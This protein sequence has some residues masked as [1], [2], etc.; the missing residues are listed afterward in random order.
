MIR[1]SFT[2]IVVAHGSDRFIVRIA[3]PRITRSAKPDPE[4]PFPAVPLALSLS[5]F[6]F[7]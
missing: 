7:P 6:T 1:P 5:I 2:A 4:V 3:A